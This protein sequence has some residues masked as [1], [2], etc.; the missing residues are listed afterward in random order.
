MSG[1][2]GARINLVVIQ[3]SPFCNIDCRYCYLPDRQ[4]RQ[5]I[6]EATLAQICMRLF[7]SVHLGDT[8]DLLWHAG[9]PLTVPIA[10][11]E[12]AI[13]L[14]K[15]HNGRQVRVEQVFQTNAT[16]I[17]QSWCDFFKSHQA[18]V[19]VSIDGPQ[20]LHDAQRVTRGGR[21]TFDRAMRGVRLLQQ[22]GIAFGNIAV[23]TNK[24]LDHPD[25]IWDFFRN[26]GFTNLA[27]NV[28][29]QEGVHTQSS[30]ANPDAANR[31]RVFFRRLHELRKA[32][33]LNVE[34]RELDDMEKWIRAVSGEVAN[35]LCSP[36][37]IVSFDWQGNISTFSPELL[38]TRLS[39]YGDLKFGNVFQCGLDDILTS[40]KFVAVHEDIQRGVAK[41]SA[42][43]QYFSVCGGGDPSNKLAENGAFDS[44]ETTHCRLNI[45]A[46]CDV[47]LESV[48]NDLGIAAP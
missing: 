4:S 1:V 2:C 42:T 22:N 8:V 41:C 28:D 7:E 13:A 35:A 24:S 19:S 43:C 30:V 18:H 33:G 3:A 17:T 15:K 32:S 46:L 39:R 34:I 44:T 45:Q 38:S 6:A 37:A 40:E 29:E 10:F 14:L 5:I 48:E 25:E 23:L 16:L 31:Y 21:G 27:F 20:W 9:E 36:L 47:V 26:E 11:Y 12:N